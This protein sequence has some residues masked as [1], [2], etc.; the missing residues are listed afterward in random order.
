[1]NTETDV[2]KGKT[3]EDIESTP[4]V[5]QGMPEVT[6]SQKKAMEQILPYVPKKESALTTP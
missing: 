1:M 6:R 2:H 4:S 5:S 3:I